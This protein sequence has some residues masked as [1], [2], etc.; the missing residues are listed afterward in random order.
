VSVESILNE[1]LEN[2]FA[3]HQRAKDYTLKRIKDIGLKLWPESEEISSPTVTAVEVPSHLTWNQLDKA[4]RA[5][6]VSFGGSYGH[7]AG[8]ACLCF[9]HLFWTL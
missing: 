4:L 5:Q 1:G 9:S 7:L 3:R 8:Y 2:V 6:G